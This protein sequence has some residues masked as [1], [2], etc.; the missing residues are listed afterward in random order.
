[1]SIFLLKLTGLAW[2]P[3]QLRGLLGSAALAIAELRLDVFHALEETETYAHL[4]I[5]EA[6]AATAAGAMR[7]VFYAELPAHCSAAQVIELSC[8]LDVAGQA[9][10]RAAPRHYIGETGVPPPGPHGFHEWDC[11]QQLPG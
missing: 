5:P 9:A 3:E 7:R 8:T 1:M 4:E 2:S 6:L 11:P 10:G